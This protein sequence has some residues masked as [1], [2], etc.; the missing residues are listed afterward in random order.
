M[1]TNDVETKTPL[2]IYIRMRTKRRLKHKE[3]VTIGNKERMGEEGRTGEDN[4][5]EDT[6]AKSQMMMIFLPDT[7]IHQLIPRREGPQR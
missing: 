7:I 5:N 6:V 4:T 2:G 3:G 1:I